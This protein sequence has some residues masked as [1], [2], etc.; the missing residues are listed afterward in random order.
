MFSRRFNTATTEKNVCLHGEFDE[1]LLRTKMSRAL[2][3]LKK[4]GIFFVKRNENVFCRGNF[5]LSVH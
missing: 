2:Q 3:L 5:H 4:Y 1:S